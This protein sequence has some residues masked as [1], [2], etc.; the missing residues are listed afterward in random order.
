MRTEAVSA[1]VRILSDCAFVIPIV[2]FDVELITENALLFQVLTAP[3]RILSVVQIEAFKKYT[4][5]S[6][7]L[8]GE[9]GSFPGSHSTFFGILISCDLSSDARVAS[10]HLAHLVD[11]R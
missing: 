2:R 4:L 8:F 5:I 10:L 7:I 3:S 11:A 1:R 6:L 9:V